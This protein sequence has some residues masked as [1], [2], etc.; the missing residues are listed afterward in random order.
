MG[1]PWPHGRTPEGSNLS[2]IA[3]VSVFCSPRWVGQALLT[4]PACKPYRLV[5]P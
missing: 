5:T 3:K 4:R 2:R 1:A